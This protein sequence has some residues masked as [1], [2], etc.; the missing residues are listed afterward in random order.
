MKTI[1]LFAYETFYAINIL[2]RS[3]NVG[4]KQYLKMHIAI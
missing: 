3:I 1:I 2:N 4:Q